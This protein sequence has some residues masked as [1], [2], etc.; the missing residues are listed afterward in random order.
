MQTMLQPSRFASRWSARL[1]LN[2]NRIKTI[3]SA[4]LL[5]LTV[6][7]QAQEARVAQVSMLAYRIT[8]SRRPAD[9]AAWARQ[10]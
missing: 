5:L 3:V 1:G 6:T 4:L 9:M 8:P 10:L 7:V 2:M